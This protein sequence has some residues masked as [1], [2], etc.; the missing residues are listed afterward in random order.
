MPD[1]EHCSKL[2]MAA[3]RSSWIGLSVV[4]CFL[5]VMSGP[6]PAIGQDLNLPNDV[7]V[8]TVAEQQEESGDLAILKESKWQV[9][10]VK[11]DGETLPAQFGQKPGDV[12]SFDNEDNATVFG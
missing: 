6:E 3:R 8:T 10:E 9:V 4:M 11:R 2:F 12:I 1:S 7:T 5:S